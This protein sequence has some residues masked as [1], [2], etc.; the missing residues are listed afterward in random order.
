MGLD[1]QAFVAIFAVD[2]DPVEELDLTL[3]CGVD[4]CIT[5][6]DELISLASNSMSGFFGTAFTG[7]SL[8]KRSLDADFGS[9]R[10]CDFIC[11]L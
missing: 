6:A 11:L 5:S 2:E 4:L 9:G 3:Q 10:F 8:T 7:A 1:Q